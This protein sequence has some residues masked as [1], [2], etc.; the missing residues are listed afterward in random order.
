MWGTMQSNY[1]LQHMYKCFEFIAN[2]H[3]IGKSCNEIR[4]GYLKYIY[5]KHIIF[6]QITD[7]TVEII[8]ILHQNL[9]I[10]TRLQ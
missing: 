9:D 1:Y 8:R 7:N 2:N 4:Q 3:N 10:E 5:G 6:Y